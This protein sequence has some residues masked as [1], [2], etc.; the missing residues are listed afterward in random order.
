[1]KKCEPNVRD[2]EIAGG[3]A[4]FAGCGAEQIRG[5]LDDSG[6][7][8]FSFSGNE[9]VPAEMRKN[10]WS[11]MISGSVRIYSGD[12]DDG[13]VC[14]TLLNAV[15]SGQPFDIASLACRG[16]DPVA[17]EVRAAGKCR[18]MF[19]GAMEPMRLMSLYPQ[20]AANIMEFFC[21]RV[22]FLNRKIRT[23]SK[24]SVE[25]RLADFLLGEFN[26]DNGKPEVVIKS[27]AELAVRLNVSRA[28]L[29]RALAAL[30]Q[31]GVIS[32]RGKVI[33]ILNPQSL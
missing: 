15:G 1:M 5:F 10:S 17:S 13:G 18:V 30:E 12:D 19:I 6:V 4:L 7:S 27:C 11:I 9:P 26:T 32:R 29:Y 8:V 20:I 3:C 23:L 25:R 33:E 2:Y 28:S 22:A 16:A 14:K 31:S 21:G 24:G